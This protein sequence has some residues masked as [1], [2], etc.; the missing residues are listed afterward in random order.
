M[1]AA[2]PVLSMPWVDLQAVQALLPVWGLFLAG[3]L[4]GQVSK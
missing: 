4:V 3:V 2:K 1:E